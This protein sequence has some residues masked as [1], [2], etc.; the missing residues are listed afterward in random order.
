M[1]L[2]DVLIYVFGLDFRCP[3]ES[4]QVALAPSPDNRAFSNAQ[5]SLLKGFNSNF[6]TSFAGHFI[7][8]QL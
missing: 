8:T 6:P 3:F 1:T 7:K 5:I 2:K 4:V